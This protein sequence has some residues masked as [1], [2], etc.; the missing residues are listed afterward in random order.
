MTD[1]ADPDRLAPVPV[2]VADQDRVLVRHRNIVVAVAGVRAFPQ[3]VMFQ[4]LVKTRFADDKPPNSAFGFA[5]LLQPGN[6]EFGADRRGP[7]G[8][9]QQAEVYF[10]GGGGGIDAG[11]ESLGHYEFKWWVALS[12]QDRGLRL[13]CLWEEQG[14][15]KSITELDVD[16]ILTACRAS[17]PQWSA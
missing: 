13:W 11:P 17:R 6:F 9:W 14:L 1:Q 7:A 15:A 5:Q 12:A 10:A 8:D 2:T 3:A 4:L 16:R